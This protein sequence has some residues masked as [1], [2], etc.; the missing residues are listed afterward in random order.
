[1]I[2]TLYFMYF[3]ARYQKEILRLRKL[4]NESGGN[5]GSLQDFNEKPQAP[6]QKSNHHHS[7][8]GK[9]KRNAPLLTANNNDYDD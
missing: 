2:L 6:T 7:P 3:I 9:K 5:S 1:M 8:Y 4:I